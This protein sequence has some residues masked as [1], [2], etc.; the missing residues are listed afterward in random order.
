MKAFIYKILTSKKVYNFI[1]GFFR[2]SIPSPFGWILVPETTSK[3]NKSDIF[4]GLYE[5]PERM[6]IKKYLS[7]DLP[8]IELGSSLGIVTRC[9]QKIINP[10]LKIIAVEANSRAYDALMKNTNISG[11]CPVVIEKS[12]IGP[13]ITCEFYISSDNLESS[14]NGCGEKIILQSTNIS[15]LLKKHNIEKCSL[16]MDIEGSE[17]EI[18][19]LDEEA[20]ESVDIMIAELHGS[21]ELVQDFI[22][23]M[24]NLGFLMVDS[25]H[26]SYVFKKKI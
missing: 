15:C 8:V 23:K 26:S 9:I 24:K 2:T 14:I 16:V 5:L 12:V 3:R 6:L 22:L 19:S 17:H 11:R 10:Q 1:G 13:G 18:I 20:F 21:K 7:P 25:K 4:F